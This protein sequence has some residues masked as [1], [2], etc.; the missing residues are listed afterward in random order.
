VPGGYVASQLSNGGEAVEDQE[1][2]K[3]VFTANQ[4]VALNL[5]ATRKQK[6]WR[7]A[8]AAAALEPYLGTRWSK[9]SYSAAERSSVNPQRIRQFTAD[10]LLAF[11]AAFDVPVQF[12]FRPPRELGTTE[13]RVT[14]GSGVEL[15]LAQ[16]L[17]AAFG[18]ED[19]VRL[20]E[21][22]LADMLAALPS[23]SD[24]TVSDLQRALRSALSARLR[25]STA[26]LEGWEDAL[27]SLQE[28]LRTVMLDELGDEVGHKVYSIDG[29]EHSLESLLEDVEGS[30][31]E[32]E[33]E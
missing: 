28:L 5:V 32:E 27:S 1:I 33:P 6:G 2:E 24:A 16:Y 7:Q 22:S 9:A 10:E 31:A 3:A 23:G 13:V 25:A 15:T 18:S 11:A 29:A 26:Q 21:S 20:M 19:G 14:A 17:R 4:L 30:T 12:F 8:E